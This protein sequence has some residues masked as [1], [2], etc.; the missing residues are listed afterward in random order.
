MFL[1]SFLVNIQ[2]ETVFLNLTLSAKLSIMMLMLIFQFWLKYRGSDSSTQKTVKQWSFGD[3]YFQLDHPLLQVLLAVKPGAELSLPPGVHCRQLPSYIC[4]AG[5]QL[6]IISH[7]VVKWR[8]VAGN[9]LKTKLP[10]KTLSFRWRRQRSENHWSR[11]F[12]QW[13]FLSTSWCFL[14][15]DPITFIDIN[16]KKINLNSIFWLHNPMMHLGQCSRAT[17]KCSFQGL[18]SFIRRRP[19][20][21][22]TGIQVC[23][24]IKKANKV[25]RLS[26]LLFFRSLV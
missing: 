4:P 5:N 1:P 25:Y 15:T 3:H 18:C 24:V 6:L 7:I 23:F 8:F 13:V 19:T 16:F 9:R 22:P 2:H 26:Q 20:N 14:M 10:Q 21:Q 17:S 11:K 12:F